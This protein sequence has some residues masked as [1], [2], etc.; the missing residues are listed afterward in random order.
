MPPGHDGVQAGRNLTDLH[1]VVVIDF[2]AF[3]RTGPFN[4]T[5]TELAGCSVPV[6]VTTT[7][8]FPRVT[9]RVSYGTAPAVCELLQRK[10]AEA[11][12]AAMPVSRAGKRHVLQPAKRSGDES[13]FF[14][15]SGTAKEVHPPP[16]WN[17]LHLRRDPVPSRHRDQ[18]LQYCRLH[19]FPCL[20]CRGFVWRSPRHPAPETVPPGL[21][22][23]VR[24]PHG[25]LPLPF[26]SL[27]SPQRH[28][29]SDRTVPDR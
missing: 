17:A 11:T 14:F 12:I 29:Q 19:R 5:S 13:T 28:V 16:P 23:D 8:R 10:K 18:P 24:T 20:R 3:N 2:H 1:P 4:A 9:I 27:D 6:A 22:P 7:V 15:P 25:P 21:S 26:S